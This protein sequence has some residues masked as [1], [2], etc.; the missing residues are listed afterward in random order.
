MPT[1]VMLKKN[2]SIRV[3]GDFELFDSEGNAIDLAGTP[4]V[5][6]CRCAASANMPYCDGSHKACGFNSDPAPAANKCNCS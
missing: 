3:E 2:G 6:L 5:S 1:K 4:G